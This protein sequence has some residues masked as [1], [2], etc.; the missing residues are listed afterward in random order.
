MTINDFEK[1]L[2][3]DAAS[4]GGFTK[5]AMDLINI[6]AEAWR[7]SDTDKMLFDWMMTLTEDDQDFSILD[8]PEKDPRMA[9]C[10]LSL[11][12]GVYNVV[13]QLSEEAAK[14]EK[15]EMGAKTV[16]DLLTA[17]TVAGK[18]VLVDVDRYW[19]IWDDKQD[20]L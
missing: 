13:K 5:G 8:N 16:S 2:V 6:S 11:L 17:F 12:L 1:M 18:T 9:Y 3:N 4:N 7:D 14:D 15:C 20:L 19:E 10:V